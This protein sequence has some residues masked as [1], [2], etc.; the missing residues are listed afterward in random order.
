MMKSLCKFNGCA[1]SIITSEHFLSSV[2]QLPTSLHL[3]SIS[4]ISPNT[5]R[6]TS[7]HPHAPPISP[8]PHST[9]QIQSPHDNTVRIE[10][11]P[12]QII[13][14]LPPPHVQ[15]VQT[16]LPTKILPMRPHVRLHLLDPGRECYDLRRAR[17][18]VPVAL[19]EQLDGACLS[20][21]GEL[22]GV[23]IG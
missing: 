21:S 20:C 13:Q 11:L 19:L 18:G 15:R 14:H 8:T 23:R 3:H 4:S 2:P 22:I 10:I 17:S 1:C 5:P 7:P 6:I 12:L 9:N 16:P